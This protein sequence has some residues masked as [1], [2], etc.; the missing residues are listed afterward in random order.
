MTLKDELLTQFSETLQRDVPLAPYTSLRIGG[1]AEYLIEAQTTIDIVLA[2]RIALAHNAPFLLLAGCSNVLIADEGV[3]GIVVVN[4]TYNLIWHDEYTVFADGGYSLDDFVM[5][6]SKKGWA[7]LTFAAGIP[8]SLGGAIIGGAGAFG[9]LVHEYC[10]GAEILKS[11]GDVIMVPTQALGIGYRTSQARE[12]GDILLSAKMGHFKPGDADA[13]Q[14]EI[15]RIKAERKAKHPGP[16]SPS[17]GS[18]FKNL[19]PEEP[20]GRRV[21]A[22]KLLEEAGAK[23]LRVGG[24]GV[25]EHHAN[26]IVNHGNATAKDVDALANQMAARVKE[27]FGVELER[28]VR[29]VQSKPPVSK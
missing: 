19:P 9:H 2:Y 8:G 1:P 13:L 22:G 20:G 4:K 24:A 10:L 7:D 5:A 26:I 16:Q 6:V 21:P 14:S 11:T 25:Y 15:Y 3:S 12:R 28:E 17:A 29:L 18:F 27:K 23:E